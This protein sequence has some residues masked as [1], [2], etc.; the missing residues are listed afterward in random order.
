MGKIL[1][2]YIIKIFLAAFLPI[3][4]LID[5]LVI[6]LL[7]LSGYRLKYWVLARLLLKIIKNT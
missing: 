7:F 4:A 5:L 1:A 3:A 6:P 2:T